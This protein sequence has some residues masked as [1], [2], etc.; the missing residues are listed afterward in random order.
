MNLWECII[1]ACIET[2]IGVPSTTSNVAIFDLVRWANKGQDIIADKSLC[3][4]K[5]ATFS[6]V[7]SQMDYVPDVSFIR[8]VKVDYTKGSNNIY[9]LTA[10]DIIKFREMMDG[11]FNMGWPEYYSVFEG[12]LKIYPPP[13]ASAASTT[14]TGN[15]AKNATSI[16]GLAST[17]SIPSR[18]RGVVDGDV[19]EW[20]NKTDTTV[21]GVTWGLEGSTAVAHDGSVTPK[22]LTVRDINLW[23]NSR[24]KNRTMYIYSTGTCGFV[25]NDATVTGTAT[26]FLANVFPG[27]YIGTG[28]NPTKFYQILSVT[29]D[30]HLELTTNFGETTVTT[31]S[32]IATSGIDIP[33]ES[34]ELLIHYMIGRIFKKLNIEPQAT[35]YQNEFEAKTQALFIN[36]VYNNKGSYPN[37]EEF[38]P[39][40]S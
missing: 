34:S 29:D 6:S 26:N 10:K 31:T 20:T 14:F 24:Y 32:Y 13:S 38:N 2:E 25:L 15:I 39:W 5:Q 28:L 8:P 36:M 22:T 1:D 17:A 4:E 23:F 9:D 7:A 40:S 11:G 35:Q 27:D 3:I 19:C 37:D 21:T 30:T 33:A 18:G 12:K 16:T